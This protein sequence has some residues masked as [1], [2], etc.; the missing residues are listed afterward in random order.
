MLNRGCKEFYSISL[1]TLK[2]KKKTTYIIAVPNEKVTKQ[3]IIDAKKK[4]GIC[5]RCGSNSHWVYKEFSAN[6]YT[7]IAKANEKNVIT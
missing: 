2:C 1:M 3:M 5:T 6:C 4:L 7:R